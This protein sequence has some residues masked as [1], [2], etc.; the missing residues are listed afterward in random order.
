MRIGSLDIGIRNIGFAIF[1]SETNII[2]HLEIIDLLSIPNTKARLPFGDQSVV[3]L[4]KRAIQDRQALF[5][6]CDVVGVEKQ[7]T[8][9]MVLIQ[10][11]F[12]C[13]LDHV[14][15]VFQISARSVK[16]MHGTSRGKHALNKRAAIVKCLELLD[17][18]SRAIVCAYKKKDD[19]CDAILQAMY[20]A[21]HVEAL[22]RKKLACR[23][24]PKKR[25]RRS[26]KRKR[27]PLFVE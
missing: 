5:E 27:V 13:L 19:L 4:V 3:F 23:V 1:D 2:K 7:L 9:K 14:T 21:E 20:I 10:F 6:S 18:K 26:K 12:E 17:D 8:R 24:L 22:R 25:T 15:E 16:T 11:A